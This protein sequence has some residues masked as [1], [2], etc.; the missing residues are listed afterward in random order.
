MSC[1]AGRFWKDSSFKKQG[2]MCKLGAWYDFR[3]VCDEWT[4]RVTAR[5]YH[6][7]VMSEGLM[8]TGQSQAKPRNKAAEEL[9]K[10]IAE[11]EASAAT[12]SGNVGD[13]NEKADG[14]AAHTHQM[15]YLS[16]KAPLGNMM[17]LAPCLLHS[18]NVCT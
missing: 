3:R 1:T 9:A 15:R 7:L 12:G 6:M 14:R 13:N 17:L 10:S 16:N 5:R 11:E 8:G 2:R 4:K 18:F